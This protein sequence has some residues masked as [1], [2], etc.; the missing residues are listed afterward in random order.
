MVDLIAIRDQFA[1]KLAIKPQ[2]LSINAINNIVSEFIDITRSDSPSTEMYNAKHLMKIFHIYEDELIKAK[3][4]A[5][6][7]L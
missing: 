4:N 6:I 2:G 5:M 7:A 1:K 3:D